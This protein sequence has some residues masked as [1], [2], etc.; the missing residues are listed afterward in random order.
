MNFLEIPLHS[1]K[2][3]EISFISFSYITLEFSLD[4]WWAGHF[5]LTNLLLDKMKDTAKS[6]GIEGRIVNLSSVAHLHTYA[7]G[8]AFEQINDKSR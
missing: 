4:G 5:Y 2:P 8:I 6:T 1:P 7:E 3:C